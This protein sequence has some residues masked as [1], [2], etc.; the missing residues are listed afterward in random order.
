MPTLNVHL[1]DEPPSRWRRYLEEALDPRVHVT[2]GPELPE[3][4]GYEILVAGRPS[5]RSLTTAPHLHT[6]V[7][8]WAGL[9]ERTR[10]LLQDFPTL[11]VHNLHHNAV[12]AAEM[13]LALLL[14]A[15]KFLVP[16][17]RALRQHDWRPR[18]GPNPAVRL[19]GGTALVLGYG[20]IGQ[21]VARSCR[22]LG[23]SVLATRRRPRGDEAHAD[24]HLPE[25]LHALLPQAD[26]LLITLPLT[27]ETEGLIGAE[28]LA[29][30]P[31]PAV[32]VNVA[33]GA[34]VDQA[35]LYHALKDGELHAA[36]LDVWYNYPSGKD[37]GYGVEAV[38]ANTSPADYPFH[39]L[40]NVVMSPHRAGGLHTTATERDRMD[41]L[42]RLLNAAARGEPLPNRVDLARGY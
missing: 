29:L 34:I 26:A 5:R 41:H 11:A 37:A 9:P 25:A 42:A 38:R 8:P 27:D 31:S 18:Y 32:L 13:A 28:E 6:L 12:A 21:R 22:G 30:L 24:V 36:G 4:P 35:A 17:D 23:M 16:L 15:A 40:D 3:P 39:E 7:I 20:A 1:R 10:V 2:Y 33:R 14:A 19:G